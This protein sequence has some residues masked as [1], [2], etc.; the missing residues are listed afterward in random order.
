M[1][2]GRSARLEACQL[3]PCVN[4]RIDQALCG[5]SIIGA[6][7]IS[8]LTDDDPSAERRTRCDNNAFCGI[9]RTERG[10]Y[11]RN[12]VFIGFDRNYLALL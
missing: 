5:K 11:T 1:Y 2:S 10:G 12:A 7:F 8:L 4:K 9:K 3:N 6:R